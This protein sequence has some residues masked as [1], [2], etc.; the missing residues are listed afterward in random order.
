MCKYQTDINQTNKLLNKHVL[1]SDLHHISSK[2]L[3]KFKCRVVDLLG[4]PSQDA[5][6]FWMTR[7]RTQPQLLALACCL[8]LPHL[9]PSLNLMRLKLSHVDILGCAQDQ[10]LAT[11]L[12]AP[13]SSLLL[14]APV[15]W[16]VSRKTDLRKRQLTVFEAN[17]CHWGGELQG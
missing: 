13:F 6:G 17:P 14:C 4:D 5:L 10:T 2:W 7:A 16:F 1:S 9:P 15:V 3:G 8:S 12:F 11:H